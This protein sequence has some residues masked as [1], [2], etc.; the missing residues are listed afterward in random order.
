[1]NQTSEAQSDADLAQHLQTDRVRQHTAPYVNARIDALSRASVAAC[2]AAGAAGIQR[3][4][5]ELDREWDIDRALMVN[6]A[7]AGGVTFTAGLARYV[8][9]S[10]M[11]PRNKGF[12]YFFGTQ[13]AFLLLHGVAGWCPPASVFR[14]LGFRTQRE[15]EVER[16]RLRDAL[17]EVADAPNP[18][19]G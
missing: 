11:R 6:F 2:I 18:Q 17:R 13:L 19:R 14:R 16:A 8:Q 4:L 5:E 3:R 1:M 15:I 9:S 12:L 10:P 7:V